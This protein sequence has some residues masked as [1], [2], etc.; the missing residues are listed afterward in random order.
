M[1]ARGLPSTARYLGIASS[2][3]GDVQ[4]IGLVFEV[5]ADIS[6]V[7][8]AAKKILTDKDLKSMAHTDF[9]CVEDWTTQIPSS[10]RSAVVFAPCDHWSVLQKIQML[11][12]TAEALA[13]LH[14]LGYIHCDVAARNV[15]INAIGDVQL[16]DLGL[17]KFVGK[18]KAADG[19]TD[20]IHQYHKY[21]TDG[22]DYAIAQW[23]PEC[24][25]TV[26]GKVVFSSCADVFMFVN[27]FWQLFANKDLYA[28]LLKMTTPPG[29]DTQ[30]RNNEV[31]F[32][33]AICIIRGVRQ[34]LSALSRDTPP[35]A[36]DLM[37]RGWKTDPLQRLT[38]SELIEGLKKIE[39]RLLSASATPQAPRVVVH[40]SA[41]KMQAQWP[42]IEHQYRTLPLDQLRSLASQSSGRMGFAQVLLN[43]RES[44]ELSTLEKD[45]DSS[46]FPWVKGLYLSGHAVPPSREL[47]SSLVKHLGRRPY[48][49]FLAHTGAQK[50]VEVDALNNYLSP[51]GFRCFFDA[52]LE[53][54]GGSPVEH[55][56]FA[57]KTSRHI[58]VVISEAFMERKDPCRELEYAVQRMRWMRKKGLWHSVWIILYDVSV[59]EFNDL[60][61]T[62]DYLQHLGDTTAELT[63]FEWSKE[64]E[65]KLLWGAFVNNIK[66]KIMK[67]DNR[68][69]GAVA[70]WPAF[71]HKYAARTLDGF[72]DTHCVYGSSDDESR[73]SALRE[74]KDS[75][76]PLVVGDV[77]GATTGT[78][79]STAQVL[80][81]QSQVEDLDQKP[82][83]KRPRVA[84][85]I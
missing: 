43:Q 30:A 25:P 63:V 7:E 34:C 61:K 85:G 49:V 47:Q 16:A 21:I 76:A 73:R 71:L 1:K 29:M 81:A 38:M 50:Q 64:K 17:S 48:D 65:G 8:A 45:T 36:I 62:S 12:K 75:E 56:R 2:L 60:K 14:E 46:S 4:Q 6:T 37:Q 26:D 74:T 39:A 11:R 59:G 78:E 69:D 66:E 82:P 32:K 68:A 58:M 84:D 83:A 15:L 54:A 67:E 57:L 10:L 3:D 52:E 80:A 22:H 77:S 40:R 23:P 18:N 55:M 70:Q 72:P 42:A 31:T 33:M 41:T 19:I 9:S 51:M 44:G 35:E 5:C 53:A 13:A 24:I 28:D 79:S 27:M 20:I